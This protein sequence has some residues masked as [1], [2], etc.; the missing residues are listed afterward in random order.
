MFSIPP[1]NLRVK[2]THT[3]DEGRDERDARLGTRNGLAEAEQEREVAVDAV[4]ALELARSLDTLPGRRDLDED[5]LLLDAERL[6]EGNELLR[7][8]LGR[9][10]VEGQTSV[11]LGGDTAGDD[12]Q[13]LLAE[14]DKLEVAVSQEWI[15]LSVHERALTRRSMAALVWVSM[16]PPLA[17]P[18]SMA[19]SI[20]RW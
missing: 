17:L 16:S 4:V 18:A 11:D 2:V 8:R 7:L 19:A 6:V 1:H 3:A 10:L 20:R 13:D 9:L 5:A 14:L 12:L 15:R